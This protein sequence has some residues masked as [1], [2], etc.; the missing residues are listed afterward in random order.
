MKV[1]SMFGSLPEAKRPI[2][3]GYCITAT[4]VLI[5]MLGI[6]FVLK[7]ILQFEMPGT[8][9]GF[10]ISYCFSF[11]LFTI[12]FLLAVLPV[13]DGSVFV[14]GDIYVSA[15][16]IKAAFFAPIFHA[17]WYLCHEG[18][19][20]SVA[21]SGITAFTSTIVIAVY[22]ILGSKLDYLREANETR[23]LDSLKINAD[24]GYQEI[25]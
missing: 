25:P 13:A 23:K 17:F 20:D 12:F 4:A 19:G 10:V 7:H 8:D 5:M 1:G 6:E 14:D 18:I 15:T 3:A 2:Y 24:P 22:V 16:Q 11:G 9:D 21:M